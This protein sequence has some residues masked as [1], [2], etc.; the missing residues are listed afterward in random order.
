MFLGSGLLFLGHPVG[1]A[2]RAVLAGHRR[3]GEGGGKD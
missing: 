3:C 1:C 2:R